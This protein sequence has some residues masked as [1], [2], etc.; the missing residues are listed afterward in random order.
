[1]KT[2]EKKKIL[3]LQQTYLYIQVTDFLKF[4]GVLFCT[5]CKDFVKHIS[6]YAYIPTVVNE[7]EQQQVKFYEKLLGEL[8]FS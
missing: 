8:I 4:Y 3:I 5:Y 1:M 6:H 7:K 2:S